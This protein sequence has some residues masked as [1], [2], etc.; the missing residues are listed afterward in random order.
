MRLAIFWCTGAKWCCTAGKRSYTLYH[1]AAAVNEAAGCPKGRFTLA[2][3]LGGGDALRFVA[4]RCAVGAARR[5]V[6]SY[7]ATHSI[8]VLTTQTT[9]PWTCHG[10]H[11]RRIFHTIWHNTET[12]Q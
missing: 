8:C 9:P 2:H 7:T 10:K 3:N 11:V 1:R 5:G 6:P 12:T 4:V